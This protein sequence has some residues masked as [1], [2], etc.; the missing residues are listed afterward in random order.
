MPNNGPPLFTGG[1]SHVKGVGP[2][3]YGAAQP[4]DPGGPDPGPPTPPDFPAF[5]LDPITFES[6]LD[7]LP[8]VAR[9][10]RVVKA[11]QRAF[12]VELQYANDAAASVYNN[13]F[14]MTADEL[15][16]PLWELSLGAAVNPALAVENRRAILTAYLQ[17]GIADGAGSAWES[18]VQSLIGGPWSYRTHD[19]QDGT[20]PPYGHITVSIPYAEDSPKAAA[21]RRLL[22]SITPATVILSVSYDGNFILDRS[23]LDVSTL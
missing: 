8:P 23:Q 17:R 4:P 11:C 18:V 9:T 7:D 5:D 2:W 19:E 3:N 13:M 20:T 10:D 22:E 12:A 15:G 16:L 14:V 1:V 21:L 6:L